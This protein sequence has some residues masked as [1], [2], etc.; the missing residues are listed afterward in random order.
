[1]GEVF[2]FK[3]SFDAKLKE[4]KFY[5]AIFFV[6]NLIAGGIVLMGVNLTAITLDVEVMN[7]LLLPLV[8][9]LLLA[10]EQKA[11]P[12]EYRLKGVHMITV[13][14]LSGVV[15]A[16]GLYMGWDV[17]HHFFIKG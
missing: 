13:W 15:I 17:L 8:L 7:A 16:F 1:M 11:L 3:C 10:I 14:V 2:G 9:G 4:A 12:L 6:I 5:Y